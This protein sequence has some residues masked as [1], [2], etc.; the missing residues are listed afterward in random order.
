M[1]VLYGAAVAALYT[2]QDRLIF[3]DRPVS[4]RTPLDVG[5]S[6]FASGFLSVEDHQSEFWYMEQDNARGVVLFSHGLGETMGERL[7]MAK[8]FY[9]LGFSIFMYEYG[10]YWR[11]TGKPSEVRCYADV[12]AAWE[13]LTGSLG[14]PPER[15]LVFGE[16][17]GTGPSVEL[18]HTKKPGALVLLSPYTSVTA[19]ASA[20]Y[21]YFPVGLLL[22]H[23]FDN[24][25][26]IAKVT[27]PVLILHGVEDNFVPF[28][29]GRALFHLA[30]KPKEF[31]RL[32]GGHGTFYDAPDDFRRAVSEFVDPLF[33][34]VAAPASE[35]RA[36]ESGAVS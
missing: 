13:H 31:A 8:S 18:A 4:D 3:P 27:S 10:G 1:A 17:L 7:E 35:I 32:P 33:P 36:S 25:S 24:A 2:F 19:N 29:Q 14:I 21:P 26:K 15:I 30:N 20:Q 23:R 34:R 12:R 6:D 5:I 22:K 9:D 16:S 11:S 28:E